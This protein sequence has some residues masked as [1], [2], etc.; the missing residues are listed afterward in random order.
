MAVCMALLYGTFMTWSAAFGGTY[1]G[2]SGM[3]QTDYSFVLMFVGIG[4]LVGAPLMGLIADRMPRGCRPLMIV[5]TIGLTAVWAAICLTSDSRIT[6]DVPIQCAINFLLGLF[7][8]AF[9]LSYGEVKMHY[10]LSIAGTVSACVNLFPFLGGAVCTSV[11][12]F[13][14]GG[15]L[16]DFRAAWWACLLLSFLSVVAAILIR[17]VG[18]NE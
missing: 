4:M 7:C 16:E 9:I 5:L 2:R 14:I 17:P 18:G 13:L 3:E 6:E 10:P 12:G 1:Y 8:S 15:S 11:A